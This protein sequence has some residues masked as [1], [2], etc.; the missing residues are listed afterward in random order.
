MKKLL[1]L[2]AIGLMN[3]SLFAQGNISFTPIDAP[4]LFPGFTPISKGLFT[5]IVKKGADTKTLQLEQN[6]ALEIIMLSPNDQVMRDFGFQKNIPLKK[7]AFGFMTNAM[8][9]FH[10][11]DSA[12]IKVCIDSLT[13]GQEHPGIDNGA[14]VGYIVK[15]YTP[16]EVAKKEEV[17]KQQAIAKKL[18]EEA[19]MKKYFAANKIN[20][21]RTKEG[22]YYV[23]T[24]PGNGEMAASGE[25]V[26]A[27]Y[28][29]KLM[30]GT[31]FDSNMDTVFH[32]VSPFEFPLN[33]HR[34]IQGWDLAFGIL[35]KGGK[36][37]LYVPSELAYGENPPPGGKIKA[38]DPLIFDVELVDIKKV[39][40]QFT[41]YFKSKNITN[42]KKTAE[43]VYYV[44]NNAGTGATPTAGQN[45]TANYTGKLL[46]GTAFDSSVDPAFG[47]VSPFSF[48]VGQGQVIRGWDI[49]FLLLNKGAKATLYIP[50]ELAYG[51]NSPSAKIPANS[52][53]IFEVELVDFK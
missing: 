2:V 23:I 51:A 31:A 50:S 19:D 27:N 10:E 21:I 6:L 48:N 47:H 43:G 40:D 49:G 37:T 30:D 20:P 29:G 32:H 41:Q 4:M 26:V 14:F 45:V 18:K 44:I 16:A 33:Q 34:V 28:R 24:K 25:T 9:T 5:R 1:L 42:A 12:I 3:C 15:V 39:E 52:P 38:G 46:D 17:L 11:G 53:M 22:L 7:E 13:Q 35:S 8:L 36:A